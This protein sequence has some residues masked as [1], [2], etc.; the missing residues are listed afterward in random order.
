MAI[1][2]ATIESKWVDCRS[3]DPLEPG[4]RYIHPSAEDAGGCAEGCCD[5]YLCPDCGKSWSIESYH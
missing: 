5:S 4:K 3:G 1:E 2:V